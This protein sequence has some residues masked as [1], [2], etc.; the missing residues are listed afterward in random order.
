ML[1]QL[2]AD[3][4]WMAM[5][6]RITDA[7]LHD[8]IRGFL[9]AAFQFRPERDLSFK[10]DLG[11]PPLPERD[12]IVDRGLQSEIQPADRPQLPQNVFDMLLD[13]HRRFADRSGALPRLLI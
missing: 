1:R 3:A 12:Q 5:P 11:M 7:F 2:H 10:A 6:E 4:A 13:M 8:A 9:A